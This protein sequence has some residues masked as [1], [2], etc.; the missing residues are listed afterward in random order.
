MDQ[1]VLVNA[2]R[3]T[4]EEFEKLYGP[5]VLLLLIAPDERTTSW[6]VLV[7]AHGLD[8]FG[9]SERTHLV[10]RTLFK[11]LGKSRPNIRRVTVLPTD[12]RFVQ[13]FLSRYANLETGATLEAVRVFGVDLPWAVVVEAKKRAA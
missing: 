12:D 11:T 3:K 8:S 6:E 13:V 5:V 1:E 4:A 2:F 7:S 10:A 9:F